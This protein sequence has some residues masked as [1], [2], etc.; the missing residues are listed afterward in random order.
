MSPTKELILICAGGIKG[1]LDVQEHDTLASVRTLIDQELDDDLIIPD[2]AF[3]VNS[4]RISRKQESKKLAWSVIGK[5]VSLE[6]KRSRPSLEEDTFCI[7]EKKKY[8]L[9]VVKVVANDDKD[10]GGPSQAPVEQV[11]DISRTCSSSSS[12]L[13]PPCKK[14]R[15][16][17]YH[18]S[19][20]TITST[21]TTTCQQ[22]TENVDF[23][24]T[25]VKKAEVVV[26]P[27]CADDTVTDEKCRNG[28]EISTD[29]SVATSPLHVS[30]KLN[31]TFEHQSK[32][33]HNVGHVNHSSVDKKNENDRHC[34]ESSN[35]SS[36]HCHDED[37][38][39]EVVEFYVDDADVDEDI[40]D[41][42]DDDVDDYKDVDSIPYRNDIEKATS[43]NDNNNHGNDDNDDHDD[44]ETTMTSPCK[45]DFK[46]TSIE[47]KADDFNTGESIKE[48]ALELIPCKTDDDQVHALERSKAEIMSDESLDIPDSTKDADRAL[49][50]S[51]SV[52]NSVKT[53]L[54]ENPL[55][56]SNDRREEWINEIN[57]RL[58]M[59]AP[60]TTVGV[61]GNTGVG[62]VS[63]AHLAGVDC[64]C[65]ICCSSSR[66]GIHYSLYVLSLCCIS[67][68]F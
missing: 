15:L 4:V 30:K 47:K 58:A 10:A 27:Y 22:E 45:L 35:V 40:E 68:H 44:L 61:L 56:C 38:R 21:P 14:Q 17:H 64:Y 41:D 33:N 57:E 20:T 1:V 67:L 55:F 13:P 50:I 6:S 11:A 46:E 5:V 62:K 3:H 8:Q 12:S 2:F 36:H 48:A 54:E 49:E 60:K 42:N 7:V 65:F 51:C 34:A 43:C 37:D 25:P 28:H 18:V 26:T 59:S 19:T 23:F 16:T 9:D 24:V 31:G 29:H 32:M 66:K 63:H 39:Y 52:L 53:L